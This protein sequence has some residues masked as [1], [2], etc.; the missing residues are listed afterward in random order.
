MG[1]IIGFDESVT[2]SNSSR[3]PVS[4]CTDHMRQHG[5][6]IVEGTECRTATCKQV[7]IIT[8]NLE[9]C[10]I[11]GILLAIATAPRQAF[12]RIFLRQCKRNT[13]GETELL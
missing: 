13:Y 3:P 5:L 2:H 10:E 4:L 8:L 9:L 6:M 7:A 11:V 12:I 1:F